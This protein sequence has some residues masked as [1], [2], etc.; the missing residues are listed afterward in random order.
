MKLIFTFALSFFILKSLSYAQCPSLTPVSLPFIEDFESYSDTLSNN[1]TL[2]C[3][4]NYRWAFTASTPNGRAMCGIGSPVNNGGNGAV[5]FD[6]NDFNVFNTNELILTINLNNYSLTDPIYL[7]FDCNNIADEP[8]IEDRIYIRG[9]DAAAWIEVYDWSSLP[10]NQWK[11]ER[12]N[13]QVSDLLTNNSQN[14]SSSFQVKFSQKDNYGYSSDGFAIDN[15]A[16]E[17]VSCPK[18]QNFVLDYQNEDSIILSWGSSVNNNWNI[19]YGIKGFQLGQGVELQSLGSSDTITQLSTNSIYEFYIQSNCGSNDLSSWEGPLTV[20]TKIDND[21][22]CNAI[23]ISPNGALNKTHNLNTSEQFSETFVLNNSPKNTIWFK[24]VVPNSG[25]LAIQTCSSLIN[26]EIGA[27]YNPSSCSDLTTFNQIAIASFS[28]PSSQNI[29]NFPGK[30]AVEICNLPPGDTV[31]FW[32]GSY[33]SALEGEINFSVFD[34]SVEGLSGNAIND[35][36]QLCINDTLNLFNNI[37]NYNSF[38]HNW[39]WEY[40]TNSNAIYNDSLLISGL[41]TYNSNQL[42][43]IISNSCNSDT[44]SFSI[45]ISEAN[46]AGSTL[47]NLEYCNSSPIYLFNGLTGLVETNGTWYNVTDGE[48]A[49]VIFTPSDNDFGSYDFNYI[50][51]NNACEA[52]TAFLTIGVLNCSS[53]NESSLNQSSFFPNP[54][55][56]VFKFVSNQKSTILIHELTGKR[57]KSIDYTN[58]NSPLEIDLFSFS[59]GTYLLIVLTENNLEQHKIIIQ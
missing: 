42:S 5:T 14:Y 50:V 8:N 16:L 58:L 2:Y 33:T 12:E 26:T 43:Y 46:F 39:K 53:V 23:F 51:D 13:I 21:S 54:S 37:E 10:T 28:S 9:N 22:S 40:S 48:I 47:S 7:S 57:I 19:Q 38:D 56:G 52:D 4:G 36:I 6:V 20:Y 17:V 24:T 15:I 30:A 11:S 45:N 35:T 44:T 41:T 18:A 31:L 34:Y 29:C 49:D 27:Y 3:D 25:H 1:D 55:H 32:I 59:K